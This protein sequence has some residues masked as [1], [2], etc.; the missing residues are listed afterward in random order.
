MRPSGA[1]MTPNP[2]SPRD[3]E[4]AFD[5]RYVIGNEIRVGGQGV[6]YRAT[7]VRDELGTQRNNDVA[8]KLHLDS[9]YDERV[10]RE[11]NAAKNL[12]HPTLA[13]LLE[14]GSV[15]VGSKVTRY[16]AWEF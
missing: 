11:I 16:I 8:L 1:C 3:I 2:F 12:R 7:R 13:T 15:V 9:R 5:H 4:A 14:E 6:V 10:E